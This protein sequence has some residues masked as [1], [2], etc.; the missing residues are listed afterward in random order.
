MRYRET[1]ICM[2]ITHIL[3]LLHFDCVQENTMKVESQ[4]TDL[5]RRRKRSKVTDSY[6]GKLT[7]L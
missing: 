2:E 4:L 6:H 3:E 1:R 5:R 7:D